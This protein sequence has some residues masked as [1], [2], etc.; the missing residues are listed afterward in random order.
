MTTPPWSILSWA[1]HEWYMP[2][3]R[4]AWPKFMHGATVLHPESQPQRARGASLWVGQIGGNKV[5]LAWDWEEVG[6]GVIA[7]VD[8][9]GII[10]NLVFLRDED[11]Y[12]SALANVVS[13]ARLVHSLPWQAAVVRALSGIKGAPKRSINR[14][15]ALRK[16]ALG[17]RSAA[18]PQ[19]APMS[20]A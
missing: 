10:S 13:H 18:I 12:Q 20:F 2:T 17:G 8:G 11:H 15:P 9:N 6:P 5:G 16:K 1:R 7:L 19:T 14:L 3:Q 4:R